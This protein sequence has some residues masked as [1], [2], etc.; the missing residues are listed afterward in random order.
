VKFSAFMSN[1]FHALSNG[2]NFTSPVSANATFWLLSVEQCVTNLIHAGLVI[3]QSEQ[4]SQALTLPALRCTMGELCAEI[5]RQCDVAENLVNYIPEP[6]LEKT[7]GSY[8]LL[9]T[10]MAD[11]AGFRHDGN[12]SDL[13][14]TVLKNLVTS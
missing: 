7:F 9:S 1:G 11:N 14:S 2:E 4:P 12:L 10:E 6:D 5:S 3:P 8:P 13:V